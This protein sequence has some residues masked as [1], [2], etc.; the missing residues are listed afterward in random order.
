MKKRQIQLIIASMTL[1]LIGLIA[2]Q[3][4]WIN[5]AIAVKNER[6]NQSV[7][8]ALR[9]V[10]TK[11]EKQEALELVARKL[12]QSENIQ[13]PDSS[14][15]KTNKVLP[16]AKLAAIRLLTPDRKLVPVIQPSEIPVIAAPSNEKLKPKTVYGSKIKPKQIEVLR[17]NPD[18]FVIIDDKVY[19]SKTHPNV[20]GNISQLLPNVFSHG[21]FAFN[22]PDSAFMNRWDSL[23]SGFYF[24]NQDLSNSVTINMDGNLFEYQLNLNEHVKE[25][26]AE[27]EKIHQKLKKDKN[28]VYKSDYPA[29]AGRLLADTLMLYS[30]SQ[31]ED[32]NWYTN[33]GSAIWIQDKLDESLNKAI[34]S[35]KAM[36]IFRKQQDSLLQLY[37]S[38]H[39]PQTS[40]VVRTAPKAPEHEKKE[41]KTQAPIHQDSLKLTK[42]ALQED[43]EK[44]EDKSAM[45]KDVFSELVREKKPVAE[46]INRKML[47]TLL[48]KEIKN[49]QIDIPYQY[50]I[51]AGDH[52]KIVLASHSNMQSRLPGH[53]FKAA[54]FPTD[55]FNTN[56]LLYIHFPTQQQYIMQTMWTV[57]ASSG[58]MVLLI[59]GCFYFAVTTILK[60]KKLSEVKN[61]F[62]NNMTHEF[63]TPIST[64]SLA[65]EVLQDTEVNKNPAQM[66]RYLH[67]I[68]DENKRLGMQV[69][70]VLQ[71]ALL[72]KGN[73][74]LKMSKVDIHEVIDEVLQNIGVQIEKRQG[75]VDL[76]LQAQHTQIEADEMHL[77]NI[78]HN[79]LDNAN[80]YSPEAPHIRIQTRSLVD[81]VSITIADKG[82][83]MS[84]E[85]L[86]RIF[87]RFYRVPTGNVHNVKGFG[88]G[89]SYVKTI[90]QGHCG[91]IQVESQPGAGSS[92]E[93]FLP[94][95]QKVQV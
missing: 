81:G 17:L 71:A 20:L 85:A 80:K 93:V 8:E 6:F 79:L 65:C 42:S 15:K 45:V 37:S 54:L 43:F 27:L 35:E 30:L 4:Y 25:K 23:S 12:K 76:D 32:M 60:Q 7:Q 59:L 51:V 78:I 83:G 52:N 70:K 11:L 33:P 36:L 57:L 62:I 77:T 86:S 19:A 56:D 89:L 22:F 26:N 13:Q 18:E 49:H 21:S 9:T 94:Y 44:V 66:N 16:K 90:L 95:V 82:I 74:K 46:R 64:I 63:K 5:H 72:D 39:S 92:F 61:D 88:L 38:T 14:V 67:I 2:F 48:R 34:L 31:A 1:A 3:L 50:G 40:V 68:R 28:R 73:L 91:R 55:V 10:V 75:T 41:W 24:D 29:L 87:D 47:D 84:K 58:V 69:E 53:A